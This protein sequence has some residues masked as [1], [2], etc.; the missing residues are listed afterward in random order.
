M[1]SIADSDENPNQQEESIIPVLTVF[2]NKSIIK[3]ICIVL[4][5]SDGDHIILIGR[6]PT[7]N[8]VLT[9]PSISRFHLQ[10]R[11]TPSS[12]SISLLDVSSVHGTWVSGRKL[13]RG[14]SVE[15]KGGDSFRLGVSSRIYLLRFVSQFDANALKNIGSLYCDDDEIKS[16]FNEETFDDENDS[17]GTETSCCENELG[18]SQIC[19]LSPPYVQS[20]DEAQRTPIVE[21]CPEVEVMGET[22]LLCTLKECFKHTLCKPVMG[23]DKLHQQSSAAK[24]WIDPEASLNEKG[25]AAVDEIPKESDFDGAFKDSDKIEDILTTVANVFNS[26]VMPDSES[27]Q[28]NTDEEASGE[29]LSDGEGCSLDEIVKNMDPSSSNENGLA[30]VNVKPR[31]HKLE[32]FFE[33][34]ARLDNILTSVASLF[35]SENK[36]SR[37][38]EANP[39]ANFQ[40]N[41][42]VEEVNVDSLSDG[43]EENKCDKELQ[44]YQNFKPNDEG[45]SLDE[46][47]EDTMKSFQTESFNPSVA[48]EAD[49]DITDKENGTP[50]SLVAV[51]GC[52]DLDYE[53]CVEDS[54]ERSSTFTCDKA[55]TEPQSQT[56]KSRLLNTPIV[57]T[58]FVMSNLKDI[59]VIRK[60]MQK[61][62]FS[63]SDEE[64]MFTPS[65]E[66]L[67]DSKNSKSQTS[68]NLLKASFSH[69][70]Y[71]AERSTSSFSNKEN[72]TPIESQQWQSERKPLECHDSA[73][74]RKKRVERTPLQ[75]LMNSGDNHNSAN[76]SPFYSPFAAKENLTPRGA[77]LWQSERKP[78]EC[79]NTAGLRRKRVERTPLQLLMNSGDNHNSANS[80]PFYSPFAEKE[81]LTPRGAQQWQS[82]RKP[83]ECHTAELRKKRVE[84]TPLKSLMSSGGNHNSAN[85]SPFSAA[86]ETLMSSGGNH[87]SANSSLFSAAKETLMSSGGYHNSENTSPFSAAEETLTSSGGNHILANS[88]P[89]S[90]AKETLMSS[91]GNPNSANSSPFYSPFSA[92]KAIPLQSLGSSGGNCNLAN[93]SPF[94]NPFSAAKSILGVTA[95]TSNSR[96]ISDKHTEPSPISEERKRSWDM[97]VDTASLLNE[98]SRKALQLLQGLKGTRLM[99]PESVITE[100]GSMKQ[101]IGVF[102]RIPEEATLALE[103]IEECIGKTK[104]WIHIL[105][106]AFP[107]VEDQILDCALQYR[108]KDNAGQLVLLSDDINLKIKSMVKGLL[109]ETVEQFRRSLV[110]PFSERFMWPNS[111]PRGLTWSCQDDVIL[112]EKYCC[113]PLKAGLKLFVI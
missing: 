78:L 53:S 35:M 43:E 68:K 15:L 63:V 92:A 97:V 30:A 107:I 56:R 27:H 69:N 112:R 95:R 89:F 52:F 102:R 66:N 48:Q 3:N 25:G 91:G 55:V 32:F 49:L 105:D 21:A 42:I 23:A 101:R 28:T 5:N 80:S 76:S 84:R 18:E 72:L 47:V 22:N 113:F 26:E 58:K 61:D 79:H 70:F 90:A 38:E 44:A 45:K 104:W 50:Q 16:Q 37:V 86:K 54:A 51:A 99:I 34:N 103:W 7:C 93:S 29:S 1:A 60:P 65:K 19:Y 36:S 40:Q 6:H 88:S 94:N 17:F 96:H 57:D 64:E 20:V 81:N 11:F 82:E 111:S 10:I 100:L 9:H 108:R 12:R 75:S 67:E 85:S 39:V 73:G 46:T 33:E 31:E 77:Q 106:C 62:L 13:E 71:S 98:E 87:N 2:K 41:K 74:L 24:K 4:N 109:C 110:N 59:S 8:I 83:L 14:V